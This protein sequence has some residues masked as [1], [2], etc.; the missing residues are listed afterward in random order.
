MKGQW[1]WIK[2]SKNS[3]FATA[4]GCQIVRFER[5]KVL[6]RNDEEEENWIK[7]DQVVTNGAMPFFFS[8]K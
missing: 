3:E 1:V 8:L 5:G 6:I 7:T 4:I 2:P